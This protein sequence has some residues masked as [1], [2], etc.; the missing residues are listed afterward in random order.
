MKVGALVQNFAGFPETG[1]STRA[2]VDFATH[3]ESAGF[4]SVWVTDHIVLAA[5]A[6]GLV[7]AQ[8]QRNLPVFV[9]AGH[10]R[11]DR[12]ARSA[13]PGDAARRARRRGA[14]DPVSPSADNGED[15]R[16]RR[17]TGRRPHHP[18]R[19]GRVVARRVRGARVVGRRVRAPRIGHRGL[20]ARDARGM[21][22]RRRR[23]VRGSACA[24]HATSAPIRGRHGRRTSRSGSAAKATA[25]CDARCASA[26]A[27]SRSRPTRQ[28]CAPKCPGCTRA[29]PST[30][31]DP[32]ELTVALI[33]GIVVSP[34]PLGPERSPLHGTAEQIVEGLH[35]FA[36][37]GIATPRSRS[38]R[39]RRRKL[40][41]L[42]RRTRRRCR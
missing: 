11:S 7:S 21:D 39:G 5:R 8:R 1:R 23:V 19:R 15:A 18:R 16:H 31:S 34:S 27:T 25:R 37:C 10:S 6:P 14:G 22:R 2:C 12:V 3:A 42:D 17:P 20:P 40:R 32:A 33:D 29:Q 41:R 28:S 35:A 30:A 4:D 24:L 26:T 36:D 13:G 9:A 38:A